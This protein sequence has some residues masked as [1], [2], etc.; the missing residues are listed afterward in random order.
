M[1]WVFCFSLVVCFCA[2][3]SL[4]KLSVFPSKIPEPAGDLTVLWNGTFK[5]GDVIAVRCGPEGGPSL[6]VF[7]ASSS[8]VV[9][10]DLVSLRCTYN[11]SFESG[12][13]AL[14][15]VLV[16]ME[17]LVRASTP[18]LRLFILC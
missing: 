18:V 7:N 15:F 10:P 12:G 8:S 9:V 16:D 1:A 13:V 6:Y 3:L 4:S 14:D 17:E 2:E 5:S 11:I